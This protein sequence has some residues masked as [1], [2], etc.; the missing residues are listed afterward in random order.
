RGVG[1][2]RGTKKATTRFVKKLFLL[3]C[4]LVWMCSGWSTA[5]GTIDDAL[6]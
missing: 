1:N 3:T 2:K 5:K 6:A 4:V